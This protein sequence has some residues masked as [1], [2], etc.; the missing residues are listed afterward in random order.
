MARRSE[1]QPS[2]SSE[3]MNRLTGSREPV[4]NSAGGSTRQ[5]TVDMTRRD[6][7]QAIDELLKALGYPPKP[8]VQ[9]DGGPVDRGQRMFPVKKFG[10]HDSRFQMT[11]R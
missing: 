1:T 11:D 2:I 3:G 4:R 7:G 5:G 8:T 6:E 10:H 9:Q